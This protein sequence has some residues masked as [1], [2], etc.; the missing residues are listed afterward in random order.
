MVVSPTGSRRVSK[1]VS[2]ER[3]R[4]VTIICCISATGFYLPR[5]LIFASKRMLPELV[6]K[7]PPGTIGYCSDSGWSNEDIFFS[8]LNHFY[9]HGEPSKESP[10]LL[11]IDNHKTHIT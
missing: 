11:I 8:F 1:I 6:A 4:N 2:A 3:G 10:A 9:L 7:A 5:F